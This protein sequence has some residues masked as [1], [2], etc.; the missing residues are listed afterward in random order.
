MKNFT[1]RIIAYESGCLDMQ[2]TVDLFQSLV[3]SG[4]AWSMQGHYGRLIKDLIEHGDI[5]P[6]N[7]SGANPHLNVPNE[8]VANGHEPTRRRKVEGDPEARG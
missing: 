2:G 1:S 3:D 7:R 6:A 5:R 8:R 4:L